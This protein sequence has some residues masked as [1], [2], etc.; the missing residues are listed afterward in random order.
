MASLLQ[1]FHSLCSSTY[2]FPFFHALHYH[3]QDLLRLAFAII[4]CLLNSH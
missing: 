4:E 1:W 3:E 2:Q